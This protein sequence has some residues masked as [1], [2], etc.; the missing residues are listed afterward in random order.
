MAKAP[1][2]G[3]FSFS[4]LDVDNGQEVFTRLADW[5][6]PSVAAIAG[7]DP[8]LVRRE[9][10]G[11][12]LLPQS[13]VQGECRFDGDG[14]GCE[15][16]LYEGLFLVLRC[17]AQTVSAGGLLVADGQAL[18]ERLRRGGEPAADD[19]ADRAAAR[20]TLEAVLERFWLRPDDPLGMW[21]FLD[22]SQM[23]KPGYVRP[24]ADVLASFHPG[25]ERRQQTRVLVLSASLA[26]LAH[27][28][29]HYVVRATRSP[30][31]M[32]AM[33]AAVRAMGWQVYDEWREE[34]A[35]DWA[36]EFLA[37]QAAAE[38]LLHFGQRVS[39]GEIE[40]IEAP[41]KADELLVRFTVANYYAIFFA[42]CTVHLLETYGWARHGKPYFA[43]GHPPAY[44]RREFIVRTIPP[45]AIVP[46][47][48]A[49]EILW[50]E[51]E[52]LL[53]DLLERLD[54]A[55]ELVVAG[56]RKKD[57]L[58]HFATAHERLKKNYLQGG[59]AREV[60]ALWDQ[61]KQ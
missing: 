33:A 51:M 25:E 30:A 50:T 39:K 38:I 17:L 61:L 58:G 34:W 4:G 27:E 60:A 2:V 41:E 21:E 12:L 53:G 40:Q 28:L 24:I 42:L 37:D 49:G 10:R 36:R 47:T 3:Y 54:R 43:P 46:I 11:P 15:V 44:R 22:K 32:E 26:T 9:I 18:A 5:L 1:T 14:T 48:L 13:R 45:Q 23:S 16:R 20:D 35:A 6:L 29:G 57:V 59:V 55:G 56:A 31:E 19:G 7:R 8:A 52:S